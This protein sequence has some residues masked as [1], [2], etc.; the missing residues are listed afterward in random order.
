MNTETFLVPS[1]TYL[2]TIFMLFHIH[3]NQQIST[4]MNLHLW[5]YITVSIC[6]AWKKPIDNTIQEY[7]Y[8]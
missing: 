4:Q 6:N 2:S 7:A 3:I 5:L 8:I 1:D